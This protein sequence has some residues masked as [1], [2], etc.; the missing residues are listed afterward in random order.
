MRRI[1]LTVAFTDE[2]GATRQETKTIESSYAPTPADEHRLVNIVEA[3][4]KVAVGEQAQTRIRKLCRERSLSF[5]AVRGV[6]D[7]LSG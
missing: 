6:W 1:T 4:L 3:E 7:N 2:N 5:R